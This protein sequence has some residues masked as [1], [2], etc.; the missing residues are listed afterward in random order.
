[1]GE[2]FE[3]EGC[4]IKVYHKNN[5][6]AVLI[7][8]SK[9]IGLIALASF[10]HILGEP[11]AHSYEDGDAFV[12]FLF[13]EKQETLKIAEKWKEVFGLVAGEPVANGK[14]EGMRYEY[15]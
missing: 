15:A 3:F 4:E 11:F 7:E 13:N 2:E 14:E 6:V 5:K 12:L 10:I 9:P 1:M 8:H